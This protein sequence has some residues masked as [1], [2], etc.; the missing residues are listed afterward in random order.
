GRILPIGFTSGSIPALAA[1]LPL[2]KNYALVGAFWGAWAT[3]FPELSAQA[4]E[5]LLR[6]VAQGQLHPLVADVMP[7][8]Q[9]GIALARLRERAVQG[10]LV[11]RVR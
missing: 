7:L 1:N 6:L 5:R 3:R 11:L 4:D 2:L 8:E 10:R 9:F